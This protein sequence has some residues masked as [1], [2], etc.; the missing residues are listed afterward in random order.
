MNK[1]VK[2]LK[3]NMEESKVL[4]EKIKESLKEVGFD[5]DKI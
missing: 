5:M 3:V 2:E 4:D 1:L